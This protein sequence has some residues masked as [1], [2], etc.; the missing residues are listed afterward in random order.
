MSLLFRH[1][2]IMNEQRLFMKG[3]YV[4]FWTLGNLVLITFRKHYGKMS[5]FN[6]KCS[7]NLASLSIPKVNFRAITWNQNEF[8]P[9]TCLCSV[10]LA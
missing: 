9:S 1:L 5:H 3:S 8:I 2:Y 4:N 7:L 6:Y 10:G